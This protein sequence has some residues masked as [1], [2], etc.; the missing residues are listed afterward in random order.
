MIKK[1]ALVLSQ[2]NKELA[3]RWSI[4][5]VS[6][7]QFVQGTSWNWRLMCGGVVHKSWILELRL[8]LQFSSSWVL[9]SDVVMKIGWT[10]THFGWMEMLIHTWSHARRV[11]IKGTMRRGSWKTKA[12]QFSFG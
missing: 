4:Q 10:W 6:I 8:N 1:A 9:R 3:G 7:L 11:E 12:S 5:M 2:W